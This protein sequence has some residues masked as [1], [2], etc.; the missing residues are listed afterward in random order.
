MRKILLGLLAVCILGIASC[1]AKEEISS[2]LPPEA[3]PVKRFM[4]S[5]QTSDFVLFK[6]CYAPAFIRGLKSEDL[7]QIFVMLKQSAMCPAKNLNLDQFVFSVLAGE[8][9]VVVTLDEKPQFMIN[10]ERVGNDWYVAGK[11]GK[12]VKP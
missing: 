5:L 7:E 6:T 3:V 8:K 11:Q 9:T 4:K 10:V 1:S 12:S 2:N